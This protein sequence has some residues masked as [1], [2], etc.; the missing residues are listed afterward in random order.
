MSVIRLRQLHI[1]AFFDKFRDRS[2]M[3]TE[4]F[5]FGALPAD[6]SVAQL[7][8][9]CEGEAIMHQLSSASSGLLEI[10]DVHLNVGFDTE[11]VYKENERL[12]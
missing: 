8:V 12:N 2:G 6:E 7:A 5:V 4:A 11:E 9:H 10:C 1:F 3:A